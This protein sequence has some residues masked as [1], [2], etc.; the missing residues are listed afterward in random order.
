LIRSAASLRLRTG[1]LPVG[2]WGATLALLI[3]APAVTRAYAADA[4]TAG[5]MVSASGVPIPPPAIVSLAA[6]Q[7]RLLILDQVVAKCQQKII[8]ANCDSESVGPD[9]QLVLPGGTRQVR[10][11]WLRGLLGDAAKLEATKAKLAEAKKAQEAK[12]KSAKPA[13]TPAQGK[14]APSASDDSE[15]ADDSDDDADPKTSGRQIVLPQRVD[16]PPAT[17]EQRLDDARRRLSEE[18][19][20][21]V[22]ASGSTSKP[23]QDTSSQHQALARILSAKEYKTTVVNPS[24]KDRLLEKI[25][26]W[27]NQGISKLVSAGAK[28]KWIGTAAEIGF[29]LVI[30]VALV[31]FLIRLEKQ[32]RFTASM[33]RPGTGSGPASARDWQLWLQDARNAA[34]R[35]A[36]RDAIHLLY[37]ASISRL[38]GSGLW[39]A[40]RTRTPREYLALLSPESQHRPDLGALTRSFERTWYAGREANEADFQAAEQLAANLGAKASHGVATR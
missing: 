27:I 21:V 22:T 32:G 24:L 1:M 23:A 39:P 17:V 31:W 7:S 34:T 16:F 29:G 37:W 35:Q 11:N 6:Y 4:S 2:V 40:D 36:W 12:A 3:L 30:A 26:R 20:R 14:S 33:I 18:S 10:F 38:E 8:P 28:S 15:N 9:V 25:A 13:T 5:V 19:Q